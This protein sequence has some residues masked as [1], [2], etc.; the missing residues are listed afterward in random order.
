MILLNPKNIVIRCSRDNFIVKMSNCDYILAIQE[1]F[2]LMRFCIPFYQ[3]ISISSY[4]Q[5]PIHPFYRIN[6]TGTQSSLFELEIIAISKI[7]T[8]QSGCENLIVNK[9][10]VHNISIG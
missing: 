6:K 1:G 9:G 4:P 10:N 8:A 3:P 5:I 2:I 7:Y